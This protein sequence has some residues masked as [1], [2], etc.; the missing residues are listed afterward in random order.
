MTLLRKPLLTGILALLAV[1]AGFIFLLKGCLARYDERS[2]HLPAMVFEKDG[3]PV[4]FSIVEFEKTTSYSRSGGFV[5]KSVNTR[6]Y[7]QINDGQTADFISSKK[8]RSHSSVKN[9]PVEVLGPSG[10]N[11]WVFIGEPM[12]FDAFTLEKK[13]DISM[14]EKANPQLKEKFPAERKYY[15]YDYQDQQ[16][17]FT[18]TDGSKWQLN[19]QTLACSPSVYQKKPGGKQQQLADLEEA[20][21]QSRAESDTLYRQKNHQAVT[22]YSAGRISRAE[23]QRITNEFYA[24]RSEIDKRIDSLQQVKNK[25]E[26]NARDLEDNERAIESLRRVNPSFSGIRVNQDTAA[27]A[28]Y[29][30]YSDE[31]ADKLSERIYVRPE[32]EETNRRKLFTGRYIT[33]RYGYADIDK[34]SLAQAGTGEFLGGGFLL[35]KLTAQPLVL[36]D[37]SWLIVHKEKVGREGNILLSS[38]SKSGKINWTINSGLAEWGDWITTGSRIYIF[39]TDNKE[40][41]SNECNVL[42]SVSLADGSM[43]AF[44]YFKNKRR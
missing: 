39:G 25:I 4:V 17:Y 13:A 38:V 36:K 41:S 19:T 3:K 24:Q 42:V 1:V 33:S 7:I 40:L 23:Y 9:F 30:L 2:I 26:Q 11:A 21:K 10:Q 16:I 27:G 31:E 32:Y 29:G 28:W 14:L 6:Y 5:R 34:K 37:G 22:D 35:N 12:A 18:A 8:I 43:A 15:T 20:I 44:D